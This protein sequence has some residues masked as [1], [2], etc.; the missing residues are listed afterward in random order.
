MASI[1]PR[2]LLGELR[3]D[4]SSLRRRIDEASAGDILTAKDVGDGIE[5]WERLYTALG[6]KCLQRIWKELLWVYYTFLE[7]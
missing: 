4:Q 7:I 5:T 2:T 1:D 3:A 6:P